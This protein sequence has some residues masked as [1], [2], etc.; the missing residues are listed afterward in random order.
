MATLLLTSCVAEVV[1]EEDVFV[2]EPYFSLD[3]MLNS[4]E[5]WYVDIE[6]TR[7]QGEVPFLQKAFTISFQ[8]G[9]F[10]ANNNLVGMGDNGNGFGLQVGVYDSYSQSIDVHHEVD[11][12]YSLEVIQRSDN[13]LELYDP[14]ERV[15]YYLVGYQRNNF[16]YDKVFYENIHYFLH[17]YETWEKVHTSQFGALNEFDEENYLQFLYERSGN[18]FRSSRDVTGIP[19]SDI[20]YDYSGYYRTESVQNDVYMKILTLDYDYLGNEYF[21]LTVINDG[22]IRLYHPPSGTV[23]EFVGRR[24]ILFKNQKEGKKQQNEIKRLKPSSFIKA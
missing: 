22:K 14:I 2:E 12:T 11:G 4:Y 15:R 21:E 7:G 19:F 24:K 1:I 5:I 20:I 6:R 17:E 18:E 3:D 10:Y 16:D 9:R 8:R 23:Y 13:E